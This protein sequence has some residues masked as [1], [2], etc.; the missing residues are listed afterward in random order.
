MP[1]P[2]DLTQANTQVAEG[3]DNQQAEGQ[4]EGEEGQR[5]TNQQVQQP[6]IDW[7]SETNPYKKRYGDSQGQIQPLVRVLQQF[8][9]YDHNT[10]TW[11]QK[12]Q[13]VS[14]QP[15]IIDAEVERAFAGYDPEF[16]KAL[17]GYINPLRTELSELKK[18]RQDSV[19]M[20]EYNS[21]IQ[22]ARSKA[23]QEFGS[24]FDFAKDGKFNTESPLYKLANEILTAKYAQ[25]NPDGSFHKYNSADA[26]YMST[27]EAYAI[28]SK[29]SKQT[30]TD[31]G[32]LGA[33]EGKGTK[34]TGGKKVLSFEEYDKLS[35]E[36]KDAY[37]LQQSG[38]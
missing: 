4:Q 33:I 21:G 2:N 28:L 10:K 20:T 18:A 32:K 34:A 1:K 11:K 7:E 13:V 15:P 30:P 23:I 9:E 19:F 38:S 25:F 5:Q 27:V 12:T 24:E 3:E 14:P 36:Q 16:V 17:I 35:S 29:R 26:E 6:V 8:A 22:E 31:K 37:D